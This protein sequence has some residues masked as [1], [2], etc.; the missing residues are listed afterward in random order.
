M[1]TALQKRLDSLEQLYKQQQQLTAPKQFRIGIF[2]SSDT[3][4]LKFVVDINGIPLEGTHHDTGITEDFL[5]LLDP[6]YR[7]V[8]MRGGRGS[9][10]SMTTARILLLQAYYKPLK[11]LCTREVQNS[12]LDSVHQTLR[13]EIEHL[14]LHDF[15]KVTN[16]AITGSNGSE[17]I[18]KGLSDQ[19]VSSIKSFAGID[20]VWGEEAAGI[21]DKSLDILIPTIRK[22]GSRF[23]WTWNPELDTHAVYSRYVLTTDP[24]I[25]DVFVNHYNNPWFKDGTLETTRRADLV[26]LSQDW[27]KNIWEGQVLPA[28]IGAIY[29]LEIAKTFEDGRV[30]KLGID[31]KRAVHAFWDLGYTDSMAI[32]LVQIRHGQIFIVNYIED[33]KKTLA[34]FNQE[35]RAWGIQHSVNW[36]TMYLPHDGNHARHQTGQTDQEVLTSMGWSVAITPNISKDQGIRAAKMMFS[37]VHFDEKTTVKLLE[38]LKR[39]RRKERPDGSL[40]EPQHDKYSHAADAFRYLAVNKDALTDYNQ[41]STWGKPLN[42]RNNTVFK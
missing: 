28:E 4:E 19:S 2:K 27:Y 23:Y 11:V 1:T 20:I 9:G 3:P 15:Y 17:F 29:F 26:R 21:T 5:P 13:D 7:F 24:E 32:I 39:Y 42:Y 38:N 31:P 6:Q 30:T 8:S 18:F 34:E 35:L 25:K 40:G 16:T 37:Q 12:I 33:N 22:A 14:G 10:K 41:T 36:G